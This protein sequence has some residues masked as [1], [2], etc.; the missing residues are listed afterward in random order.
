M[1]LFLLTPANMFQRLYLSMACLCVFA[2][3]KMSLITDGSPYQL[4][5]A[6]QPA[7]SEESNV[8]DDCSTAIN[9][10]PPPV[11]QDAEAQYS[12]EANTETHC[13]QADKLENPVATSTSHPSGEDAQVQ[14]DVT[15]LSVPPQEHKEKA[16]SSGNVPA[17]ESAEKK[18]MATSTEEVDQSDLKDALPRTSETSSCQDSTPSDPV[19]TKAPSLYAPNSEAKP[20]PSNEVTRDYIP[21]VGMT[22]YTIVPQKSLEKLRYFEVALTLER[23]PAPGD[24]GLNIGS[25]HLQESRAPREQT[26]V[27]KENSELHSALP[28]EDLLTSITTAITQDTVNGNIPESI[29]CSSATSISKADG[30]SQAGSPVE[31]KQVK[32]PPA[33]KPKPGSFR[34]SQPKKTPG[35]YVTSAAEKSLSASSGA[36]HREAPERA[37]LPSPPPPPPVLPIKCKEDR[38][39]A[40]NVELNLKHDDKMIQITRQSSLPSKHPSVGLSLEKLRSFAAPKPYCRAT[41]SRFAQAVSSAVKRSQSLS[42]TPPCSAPLSPS[43]SPPSGMGTKGF[44]KFKV[45]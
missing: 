29:H 32:I 35:Y 43:T 37:P 38:A 26:E 16:P 42:H 19:T 20:K 25:L 24:E 8:H 23:P 40:T 10:L 30:A 4:E 17:S 7:I 33:T 27:P 18:D 14:T 39:G 15:S 6:N 41:S 9:S 1:T 22:T 36:G 3:Q 2:C 11:I 45:G 28:R 31:V 13:E 21:K 5:S 44:V 12:I 34:L